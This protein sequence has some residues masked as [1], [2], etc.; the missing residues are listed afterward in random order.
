MNKF[1]SVL[2]L[3]LVVVMAMSVF[4]GC[5][6]NDDDTPDTTIGTE[7]VDGTENTIDEA[8][9]VEDAT[10]D[11]DVVDDVVDATDAVA[12]DS[13]EGTDVVTDGTDAAADE[14]VPAG[15]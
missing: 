10:D 8:D 6:P 11:T 2:A 14:D 3:L 7:A 15:E 4:A 13:A 1:R 9:A 5:T 12:D